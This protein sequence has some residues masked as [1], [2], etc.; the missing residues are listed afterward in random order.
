MNET[1]I[2]EINLERLQKET[3][4]GVEKTIKTLEKLREGH[5][6]TVI[7][8]PDTGKKITRQESIVESWEHD[9]TTETITIRLNLSLMKRLDLLDE[10]V[11][12]EELSK[13]FIDKTM[14]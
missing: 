6:T 2:M 12:S 10:E 14:H 3:G 9:E 5:F 1:H 13:A 4:D 11:T 8:D 7:T